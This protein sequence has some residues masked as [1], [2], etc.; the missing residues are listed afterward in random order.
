MLSVGKQGMIYITV[1]RVGSAKK[2]YFRF[3]IKTTVF[4]GQ[5][6]H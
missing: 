1:F 6:P 4:A 2:Y 3:R 5:L